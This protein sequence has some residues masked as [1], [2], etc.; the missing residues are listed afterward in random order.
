MQILTNLIAFVFALGV[1]VFVHELGHF[2]VAKA[3]GCRVLTFSLG[4]GK[5]L[6]GFQ[7]GETDYRVAVLPIGGY[8]QLAGEDPADIDPADE[9]HF[10]NHPR[11][12]RILVY[13]AG[14]AMN[15]ALSIVLIAVLFMVGIEVPGLQRLDPVIG[16]VAEGSAGE[17]A[18]LQPGDRVVSVDGNPADDWDD[19]QFV[20]LASAGQEVAMQIDRD[21]RTMT[22]AITPETVPKYEIGD[23][24]IY[25]QFVPRV[26][27]VEG[28]SPAEQAGLKPGDELRSVDHRPVT[29]SREFIS[30]IQA[31]G[32]Q[33]A[34]VGVVRDGQPMT[35]EVTP[36]GE[37]GAGRIG[38]GLGVYQR[39]GLTRALAESAR[40]NWQL[41]TQTFAVI[42]RIASGRMAARSALS[43]PV[44]IAALSGAA[45]RSGFKNLLY[46][47][48]LVSIS[49]G[50]LNLLPIPVLD[51]G[52]ILLL[53][54]ESVVRRDL[55]LSFKERF[56]QVGFVMIMALMVA[57][58]YFDISKN[59]PEWLTPG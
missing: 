45:A 14:P 27:M 43:G 59:W 39:F 4:W 48:G 13:L 11:W 58:L 53:L 51:G 12:Q 44:E 34:Q 42:G 46:L 16:A 31:R 5:R 35:I 55:P 33:V 20:V 9:R 26:T 49:I 40:Y 52:Q 41:A 24:G 32:G 6:W 23:A 57:V 2:L 22:V 10:L 17:A 1:I 3:F 30:M 38:I 21:G 29:G 56:N 47:M 37:E 15:V 28:G 19:V 7:R 54:V 50:L 8:V 25:P 36:E 18:G